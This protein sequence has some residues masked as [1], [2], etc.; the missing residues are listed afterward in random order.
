MEQV[1]HSPKA[2]MQFA[3]FLSYYKNGQFDVEAYAKQA[4]SK[5]VQQF[6]DNI[7][8]S[9]FRNKTTD[10]R[11]GTVGGTLLKDFIPV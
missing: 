3:D 2:V 1:S 8:K 11:P 6:K 9:S 7:V 4:A 5:Q 10:K